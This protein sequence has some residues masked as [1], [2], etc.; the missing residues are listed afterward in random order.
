MLEAVETVAGYTTYIDLIR[1]LLKGKKVVSTTMT[2]EV[3]RVET[4]INIAL[5]GTSCALVSSGDQQ[6]SIVSHQ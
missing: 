1:P 6:A 4:A 5:N 2:K 3:E